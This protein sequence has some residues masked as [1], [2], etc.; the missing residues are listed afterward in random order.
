MDFIKFISE[1]EEVTLKKVPVDKM[2]THIII[3]DIEH[4]ALQLQD[5]SLC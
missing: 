5:I 1:A 4:G 3:R 2:L